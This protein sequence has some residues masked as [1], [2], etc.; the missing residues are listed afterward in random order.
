[1]YGKAVTAFFLAY[2]VSGGAALAQPPGYSS[3]EGGAGVQSTGNVTIALAWGEQLNP[4]PDGSRAMINLME[5]MKKWEKIPV[6]VTKQFRIGSSDL[7]RQSVVFIS[8]DTQFQLTE[9]ELNNLKEYVNGGGFLVVD[10]GQADLPNSQAAASLVQMVKDIAGSNRFEPVP[11][12]HPIYQTPFKLG[13]PPQGSDTSLKTV[14]KMYSQDGTE[15]ESK[16]LGDNK[17][18]LEGI[19]IKGRLAILYSPK[20]YTA[21]WKSISSDAQLKFGVNLIMYAL[22]QKR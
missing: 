11:A 18:F 16:V 13:G 6:T 10:N 12:T 2:I 22:S 1:M 9:T 7:M 8:T 21:R 3:E 5:A 17:Q 4:P 15:H 20:G 19:F 14:G